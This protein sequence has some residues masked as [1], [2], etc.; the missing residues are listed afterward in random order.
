MQPVLTAEQIARVDRETIQILGLPGAVLMESAGRSVVEAI[1]RRPLTAGSS[2][3]VILCGKGNNGGDGF[4]VARYLLDRSG[5]G[6]PLVFLSGKLESLKGD[7][8][9]MAGVALKLGIRVIELE[10]NDNPDELADALGQADLVVDAMLGS[11]AAGAPQGLIAEMIESLGRYNPPVVA[12]DCPS[13]VEMDTGR[14]P[15]AA[16]KADLTVT[17]G[18]EKIGHRLYPGRSYCGEVEVADIGFPE[19]AMKAADCSLHVTEPADIARLLPG[20]RPDT[21]KG[22]YGKILVVG[23]STGLTGAAVMASES[24][25][26]A[27]AGMVTAGVPQ[28]LNTVF[29]TKMTE[30]MTRPLPDG[31]TGA[32]QPEAVEVVAEMLERDIDVLALGP[33]LGAHPGTREFVLKLAGRVKKPLVIDADGLNAFEQNAQALAAIEAPVVITPHPGEMSRLCGEDIATIRRFPIR[34]ARDFA[35]RHSLVVVLK[36][37]PTVVAEPSGRAILNPT[38]SAALAKAGSGDVLTGIL[39]A[40]LAQG[41]DNFEAAFCACYLHGL[42]GDIAA[43]RKGERSV[44][45]ADLLQTIPQAILKVTGGGGREEV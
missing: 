41:L 35:A 30:A 22:D 2:R 45:A 16:V 43:G 31:A 39:A 42:A 37:A 28:S 44:V 33:G 34:V 6:F 8:A 21:H 25:L 9:L 26:A 5:E 7:A 14:V 19:K 10:D 1:E 29:E 38:G 20:R 36:G 13:G 23:G 15:A 32:I 11:G 24:A 17:F 4:V 18:A 40:L 27:G 12:V 3:P